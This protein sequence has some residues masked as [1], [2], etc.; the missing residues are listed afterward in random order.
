[1]LSVTPNGS[2]R[3]LPTLAFVEA[4]IYELDEANELVNAPGGERERCGSSS[5]IVSST[6]S[7][8]SS[9]DDSSPMLRP[10]VSDGPDADSAL[11]R[12]GMPVLG[13]VQRTQSNL[14]GPLRQVPHVHT[15]CCI[16]HAVRR[17]R[18]V[19]C[20]DASARTPAQRTD[21]P[22][23]GRGRA[24]LDAG[25]ARMAAARCVQGG[26]GYMLRAAV[27]SHMPRESERPT[28]RCR[29]T[30]IIHGCYFGYQ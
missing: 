5:S 28:N 16:L 9:A 26:A 18:G 30:S 14:F 11:V 23:A 8:E 12:G 21:Q 29:G 27:A 2:N 15:V 22:G 24:V 13:E 3:Y 7:D 6:T 17:V 4:Y 10:G 1:V 25:E 19:R 20:A